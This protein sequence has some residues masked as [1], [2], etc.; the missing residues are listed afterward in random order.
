MKYFVTG[1]SGWIGSHTTAE[2]L[3][4]GHQVVGLA[5]ND[6]GAAKIRA[7]G[8][9]VFRGTIDE[10]DALRA[11]AE[12]SDGVIHLAFN[13]DFS[14]HLAAIETDRAVMAVLLEA[15]VGSDRPFVFASGVL[16]K[17][18]PGVVATERMEIDPAT[19]GSPRIL[20][21]DFAFSYAD[22]GVRPIA[23]AFAPTVHGEGDHGFMAAYV[24]MD[25]LTG[26]SG[27]VGDG[28]N[29]WP[30]VNIADAAALVALGVEKAPA[31]SVL[32]AV[33]EQG[34]MHRDIAE[35][36]GRQ[37]GLPVRAFAD[38][39]V[40]EKAP[41][42]AWLERFLGVSALA[43]STATQQLLGWSPTHP[44]LVDDLDAGYYT[45]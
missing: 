25:R 26:A 11:P 7:M 23:A 38:G 14:A 29:T 37:T 35:A 31:G 45:R 30:A 22:K 9:E 24:S 8:A 44:T 16:G 4:R 34:V 20:N 12:A 27:Y 28:R 39:E 15:L 3:A 40:A 33:G 36:I 19:A 1:A 6:E 21:G 32:H 41:Q 10:P 13:H 2:L 42:F 5:R 43:S 17:T 18:A